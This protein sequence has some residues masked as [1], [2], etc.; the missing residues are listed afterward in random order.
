[1][2]VSQVLM[3][4][5]LDETTAEWRDEFGTRLKRCRRTRTGDRN[6]PVGVF[7]LTVL[8]GDAL[9][10]SPVAG[11]RKPDRRRQRVGQYKRLGL[12]FSR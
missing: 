12:L 11:V 7:V 10:V 9:G 6:V 4:R 5:L 8:L 3:K 2:K 1:M